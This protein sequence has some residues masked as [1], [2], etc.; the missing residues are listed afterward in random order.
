[1]KTPRKIYY[2][3]YCWSTGECLGERE[4]C[5]KDW[6]DYERVLDIIDDNQDEY[7]LTDIEF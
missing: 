2:L 3:E 1:M 5:P 6:D 7:R 4:Y